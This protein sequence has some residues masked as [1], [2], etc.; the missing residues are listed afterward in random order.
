MLIAKDQLFSI[1]LMNKLC[2]M[3]VVSG[4]TTDSHS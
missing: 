3:I 2:Y 1:R 4:K